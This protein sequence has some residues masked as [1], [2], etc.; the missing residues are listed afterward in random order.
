MQNTHVVGNVESLE[1][2]RLL[3]GS[4]EVVDGRLEITGTEAGDAILVSLHRGDS[5]QLDVRVNGALF[6]FDAA[7][8]DG[9]TVDALGG[10]DKVTVSEK[11]GPL[12]VGF[13]VDG[14]D[15]NDTITTG[16]GNDVIDGEDG[17][18]RV[19][20][21]AGDDQMTGG[22]GNDKLDGGAD[23]DTADA[24]DGRDKVTG[25]MG[26]DNLDGGAGRDSIAPGQGTDRVAIDDAN[27]AEVKDR[28]NASEDSRYR[29]TALA[30]VSAQLTALAAEAI[31]SAVVFRVE[32]TDDNYT[33]CYRYGS[34]PT[35]YRV[36]VHIE[37][38]GN[39]ELVSREVSP[40]EA[41]PAAQAAFAALHP[42]MG[43]VS[44]FQLPHSQYTIR[45]RDEHG[46][47]QEAHTENL[48][49]GTD[50]AEGDADN[51]GY[52]D[53]RQNDQSGGQDG[54]NNGQGDP[55]GQQG[56]GPNDSTQPIHA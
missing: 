15:G 5:E 21:G 23:N 27:P 29:V 33:L 37:P 50:D 46:Q 34:D 18:D 35:N 47:I 42:N 13:M 51:D 45:Y 56:D 7:D 17:N 22:D 25:G 52:F 32:Q 1:S 4:A 40:E 8:V 14:G 24:G 31:P 53:S 48:C 44:L 19:S 3:S 49:W 30:D 43:L 41:R 12:Y 10:N 20:A 28:T 38:D 16:S 11:N 39:V 55:N 26:D 6:T 9:V 54:Q 2:R 36:V